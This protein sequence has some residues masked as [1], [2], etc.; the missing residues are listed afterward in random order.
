MCLLALF[1]RL[2]DDAFLVVGANREESYARGGEPPQIL[3]GACRAVGGRDPVAGGTWLAVNEHGVLIA[4]LNRPKINAPATPRS[5]GLLVRDLLS[6]PTAGAAIDQ[7]A[8]ELGSNRYAGCNLVCADR[9]NLLVL[10][11]GD[12]LRVRPMPPGIHV[13]TSHDVNDGSD[14]RLD[15]ASRWL[16][17]REYALAND[18]EV[19]LQRLCAQSGG[20]DPPICLHGQHG[21]TVS[22]SILALR[23]PLTRSSYL[24]AQGP[25]DRTPY[26]DCSNLF[27]Q[28]RPDQ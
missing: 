6:A 25:P 7:A 8:R 10:H 18:C 19:A 23:H 11:A 24:H 1:Y 28:L 21:G 16:S 15:H 9:D 13:I 5:R 20:P 14:H 22:S 12:W 4:V 27:H 3:D 17:Q 2:V 26:A